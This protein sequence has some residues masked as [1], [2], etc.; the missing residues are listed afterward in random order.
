[1]NRRRRCPTEPGNGSEDDDDDAI[2]SQGSGNRAVEASDDGLEDFPGSRV[3]DDA[4]LE[5]QG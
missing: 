2:L 5:N 1:L 4:M 3:S